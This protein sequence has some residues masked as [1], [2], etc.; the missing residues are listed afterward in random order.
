MSTQRKQEVASAKMRH[1][2]IRLSNVGDLMNTGVPFDTKL[3]PTEDMKQK[4]CKI[5]NFNYY[6]IFSIDPWRLCD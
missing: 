6:S 5:S 2:S 1:D 3:S 4:L